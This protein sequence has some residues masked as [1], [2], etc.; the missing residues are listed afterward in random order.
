MRR[1]MASTLVAMAAL[2]TAPVLAEEAP[3]A[4]QQAER[5][6][7]TMADMQWL[8]GSWAGTGIGGHPA[9]ET[10]TYAG[11]DQLVGHFWQLNEDG[12]VKFYELI[13][14]VPDGESLMMRLK[15]FNA[16]LKGWEAAGADQALEFPLKERG[17]THWVFGPVTFTMDGPDRLGIAVKMRRSDGDAG[18]LLFQYH[19]VDSE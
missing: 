7:A 16:D 5:P 1:I 6:Q 14:I 9:G 15:H 10:F 17:D 12:S 19:R 11:D 8:A 2:A 4:A 3:V 13:T 18:Q